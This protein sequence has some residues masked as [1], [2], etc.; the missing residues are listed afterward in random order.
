MNQPQV[1][2]ALAAREEL[3]GAAS[4]DVAVEC[5]CIPGVQQPDNPHQQVLRRQ[6]AGGGEGGVGR[7]LH[8]GSPVGRPQRGHTEQVHRGLQFHRP[9]PSGEDAVSEGSVEMTLECDDL[10]AKLP[11]VTCRE[12]HLRIACRQLS[13]P[14]HATPALHP[15]PPRGPRDD[16]RLL[17]RRRVRS[18]PRLVRTPP[19]EALGGRKSLGPQQCDPAVRLS[20]SSDRQPSLRRAG[21]PGRAESHGHLHPA[22][23]A[24][25]WRELA[26]RW[27]VRPEAAA[28]WR[29]GPRFSGPD[30]R[31]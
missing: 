22:D 21:D 27:G 18:P 29:E 7:G 13:R 5:Q 6:E 12:D 16:L 20:K 28:R 30:E 1:S 17:R 26:P 25:V 19:R 3:V 8:G 4:A 11:M 31:A 24:A 23:V 14:R 10:R 15:A 2:S 9:Q